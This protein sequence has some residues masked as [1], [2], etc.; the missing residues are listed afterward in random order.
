MREKF[1][2]Q[3]FFAGGGM[4]RAG[5]GED[6]NCL[7]ANDVAPVKIRAYTEKWGSEHLDTRD[8]KELRLK[9]LPSSAD[10][11][12]ASFP[13]QDLSVAGNGLGIGEAGT[14]TTRSGALW[15]FLDLMGEQRRNNRAPSLIV[16]ENVTGLLTSNAGKDFAAI[17]RAMHDLDYLFGAVIV[18]TKHF[19]PQS[20]PRI[21]IVAVRDDV[22]ISAELISNHPQMPWHT[23]SVVRAHSELPPEI[24]SRWRWWKLG[25][26]PTLDGNALVAAIELGAGAECA[27]GS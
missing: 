16:L 18:D 13:C 2:F 14:G 22:P 12:W 21:F 15:P 4:A 8:I 7:L 24:V 25:E 23:A 6:W 17:C 3:E 11:A 1:S 27:Y 19:L 20:R 10:L 5:L 9:D 26:A